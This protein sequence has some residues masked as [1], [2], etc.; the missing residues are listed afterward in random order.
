MRATFLDQITQNIANREIR[1]R[2]S[3]LDLPEP[4]LVAGR[5]FRTIWSYQQRWSG[6]RVQ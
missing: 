6:L 5:L 2:W 4:W 1:A 3:L